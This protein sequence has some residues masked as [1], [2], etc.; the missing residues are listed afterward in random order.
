M[1]IYRYLSFLPAYLY[2]L[3]WKLLLLGEA[4]AFA[5]FGGEK[6]P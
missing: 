3:G 5:L 4:L 6:D 2:A 1:V